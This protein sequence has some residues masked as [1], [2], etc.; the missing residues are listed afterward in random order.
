MSH[1]IIQMLIRAAQILFGTDVEKYFDK[2]SKTNWYRIVEIV[3]FAAFL[4]VMY[5]LVRISIRMYKGEAN[6]VVTPEKKE[7]LIASTKTPYSRPD[8]RGERATGPCPDCGYPYVYARRSFRTGELY[9]CCG[10][11]KMYN[12][13]KCNFKGCRSY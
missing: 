3:I 7:N 5:Y 10:S 13:K 11:T 8:F 12:P 1:F 6:Y 2:Y 4:W 9:F